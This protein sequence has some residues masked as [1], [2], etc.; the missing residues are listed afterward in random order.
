M[1]IQYNVHCICVEMLCSK[2]LLKKFSSIFISIS[3]ITLEELNGDR[4][5]CKATFNATCK[6]CRKM[7][8]NVNWETVIEFEKKHKQC[9]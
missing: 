2:K 7:I 8:E 1:G 4:C 9:K 3:K 5:V 6:K